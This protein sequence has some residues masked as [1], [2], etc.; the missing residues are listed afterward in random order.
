MKRICVIGLGY[1]G[2]P[3]A[4]VLATSGFDVLGVDIDPEVVATVNE[5]GIHIEEPGLATV[6][7]A[8]IQS[9][10]LHA[11]TTPAPC[12]VYILAVP[13]PLTPDKKAD[14]SYVQA[15]AEVI[16]PCLKPGSLVI[17]ESTSPPGTCRELLVPIL[18]RSGLKVGAD[19]YLAHCPERVLP[20]R[21]LRELIS[22]DRV[23]GGFDSASAE[24]ARDLYATFVEGDILLTDLTTAELVKVLENTYRDVNIALANETA[25]LCEELGVSFK[26]AATLANR[27]PRVNVHTAGPGVGGHC[28]SVDPWFLVDRFPEQTDLI[29]L[30]RNRNDQMPEHVV[31]TTLHL[32]EGIAQPKVAALGLAFKGNIDDMRE[33]PALAIIRLLMEAG[34]GVLAHDPFVKEAP[35]PQAELEECLATADCLLLLTDHDTYHEL[36]ASVAGGLMRHTMLY[37]TRNM[38]DHQAWRDAGFSVSVLGV[39]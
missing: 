11:A 31:A 1:I 39:G 4:S 36:E 20:G 5:G 7:R 10:K 13:T 8:A 33:S 21:I 22:N 9:G 14:M 34:V 26:E 25:L 18:E 37:D 32:L 17:L 28:I 16:V 30:A 23:V 15:T 38:L 12:D 35:V 24:K 6:V 19:I 3:T 29:R 27:H 2:L